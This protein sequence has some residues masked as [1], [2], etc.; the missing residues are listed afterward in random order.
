MVLA[1]LEG[2][3]CRYSGFPGYENSRKQDLECDEHLTFR[4][5]KMFVKNKTKFACRMSGI[6]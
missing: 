1:V 4:E 3:D 2:K 6:E 5:G